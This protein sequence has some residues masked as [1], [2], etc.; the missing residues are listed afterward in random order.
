MIKKV[1]LTGRTFGRLTVIKYVYSKNKKRWWLCS[2]ACGGT[3]ILPTNHL[4]R[5]T[6]PVRSCGCLGVEARRRATTKH[7]QRWTRLYNIWLN[8]RSRCLI[9]TNFAYK[10][11]GGRGIKICPE[12]EEFRIFESWAK[13]N[14]YTDELTI[15]RIN[16]NGDYCPENC[17]W[18]SRKVQGNN[19]RNNDYIT[20][21]G[22]TRTR[23]E[24]SE[25]LNIDRSHLRYL[26][27]KFDNNLT[28]IIEEMLDKGY[29]QAKYQHIKKW[30]ELYKEYKN[31]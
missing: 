17:R 28:F 9:E 7:G 11:Y 15:D 23:Q 27:R 5:K 4:T 22:S 16:V 8:M 26:L 18:V 31:Q 13:T 19:K 2:C 21:K 29:K 25:F 12:W 30:K 6:E 3:T 24:W 14:G 20:Y 1:D 10:N